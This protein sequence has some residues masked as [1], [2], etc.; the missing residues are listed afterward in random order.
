MSE[1]KKLLIL[2]GDGIGPEVMQEAVRVIEW[3]NANTPLQFELDHDLIGGC[4]Y[5]EHGV[6]ATDALIDKAL[7]SDAVLLGAIDGPKWD[8]IPFE[9]RPA[10]GLLRLRKD[11]G[12]FANLRPAMLFDTLLDASSLR[13]EVVKG[14]DIMIVRELIGGLYFGTPRGIDDL[15]D[16]QQKGYN[17]LVYTTSE[18]ERVA[19]VAFE[20]A[21]KRDNRV[22]SVDKS[23]ALE[24]MRLWRD[25]VSKVHAEEYSDVELD[26]MFVDN[27]CMQL[28]RA[29]KQFDVILTGNL[30]GDIV[31]DEASMLTGS[32]GMLP[33]AALGAKDANGK[34]LALYEPV[35]GSAPDI[36]GQG[37]ANPLAT[38]LSFVMALRYSFDLQ[39]EADLVEAAINGVL[40][41]GIRT[42]DLMENGMTKVSTTEM[43]DA[44]LAELDTLS[45]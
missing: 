34:S 5:D 28:V 44:V 38:I 43:G 1:A 23:N 39:T 36:T 21:R 31:S 14:L 40:A 24:V 32:I 8:D 15:E 35:H 9:L 26:H 18:I 27:C 11:M 20:L 12:L 33:S 41:K 10:Q 13:P 2:P 22:V 7:A 29:P 3:L 4:S 30:F 17:T 37:V 25:V 42:P 19:R 6:P 16:G 45:A